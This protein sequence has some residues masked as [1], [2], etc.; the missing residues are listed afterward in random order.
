[1]HYHGEFDLRNC[2]GELNRPG[3]D[4][5]AFY[6]N[7]KLWFLTWLAELQRRMLLTKEYKHITIN[8]VHPGYVNSEIWNLAFE[9][10][11]TPFKILFWKILANLFAVDSQQGS[12]CIVHGIT[13]V[14]TGPDPDLQGVGEKGGRGGGKYF[15]RTKETDPMPHVRD[16]DCRQRVWRKTNEELK[17]QERGLLDVLGLDYEVRPLSES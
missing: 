3:R 13:A 17:L 16:P 6:Q 7:N 1:M 2:N 4:G 5:V 10:W 15:S 14:E 8:G 9:G 12:V 11:F